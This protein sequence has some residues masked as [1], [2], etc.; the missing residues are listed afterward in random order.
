MH[1]TQLLQ[2]HRSQLDATISVVYSQSIPTSQDVITGSDKNSL[3]YNAPLPNPHKLS[4][5]GDPWFFKKQYWHNSRKSAQL[6][7][8]TQPLQIIS[9]NCKLAPQKIFMSNWTVESRHN[10]W[11]LFL[12]TVRIH[13]YRPVNYIIHQTYVEPFCCLREI[14]KEGQKSI[15]YTI[16]SFLIDQWVLYLANTYGMHL[17]RSQRWKIFSNIHFRRWAISDHFSNLQIFTE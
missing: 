7:Q 1:I 12:T 14:C 8:L 9:N 5:N 17:G 11:C 4:H 13:M 2:H 3:C 16:S 6:P 15:N 10:I